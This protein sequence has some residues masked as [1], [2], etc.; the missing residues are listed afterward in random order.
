MFQKE[1]LQCQGNDCSLFGEPKKSCALEPRVGKE[2]ERMALRGEQGPEH[3]GHC[4][5]STTV[6]CFLICH[7]GNRTRVDYSAPPVHSE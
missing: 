3:A 6:N 2:R 4:S 7:K 5:L 1:E